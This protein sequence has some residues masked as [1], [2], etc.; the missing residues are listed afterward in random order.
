MADL[1]QFIVGSIDIPSNTTQRIS[2]S[3]VKKLQPYH[4]DGMFWCRTTLPYGGTEILCAVPEG[5]TDRY[6]SLDPSV[7]LCPSFLLNASQTSAINLDTIQEVKSETGEILYHT[8]QL[9]EYPQSVVDRDLAYRLEALFNNG[10]LSEEIIC[11]GRLFTSNGFSNSS[12]YF[13]SKQS[14]EFEYNGER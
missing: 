3:F 7:G 8:I 5:Y 11:T 9:G 13:A 10:A 14:P 6:S 4:S 2:T 1:S 12:E